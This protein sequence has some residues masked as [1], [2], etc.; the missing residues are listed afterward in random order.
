MPVAQRDYLAPRYLRI[1]GTLVRRH[2]TGRLAHDLK[3]PNEGE[4]H[5]AIDIEIRTG[6]ARNHRNSL[7]RVIQNVA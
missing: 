3:E 4:I 5:F 6:L 1:L 7:S 2:P